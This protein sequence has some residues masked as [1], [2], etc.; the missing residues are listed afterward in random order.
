MSS[1]RLA[2]LGAALGLVLTTSPAQAVDLSIEVKLADG[3]QA[4]ADRLGI[5]TAMIEAPMRKVVVDYFQANRIGEFL[6]EMGEGQSFTNR[7]LGVD[8]A[9]D[10]DAVMLGAAGNFAFNRD[11]SLEPT[12]GDQFIKFGR[13]LN[14]TVMAGLN[15]EMFGLAPITLYTNY[16]FL[17]H[18]YGPFE[19]R[20]N[21]FGL[22][23][24][25]QL[26]RPAAKS[27]LE[28]LF[29]W[30]GFDITTG[31]EQEKGVLWLEQQRLSGAVPYP[32]Q[33]GQPATS[34]RIDASGE[35]SF[36]TRAINIPIEVSTNLRLFHI[37]SLYAGLGYDIKVASA[38]N[39]YMDA[40][41]DL[42]AQVD[43]A[44]GRQQFRAAS[45]RIQVTDLE[46]LPNGS[47]RALAGV[48]ANLFLVKIFVHG[49]LLFFRDPIAT[50]GGGVRFAY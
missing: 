26:F 2:S 36:Y 44:G 42:T 24:Q 5:T 3:A 13:G 17:K 45:A 7:G 28:Q 9:S 22:H 10:F 21:N 49:N 27:V 1:F 8:Y 34:V 43:G 29:R 25:L 23:M 46:R 32:V 19:G 11:S 14:V 16:F 12:G 15:L 40:S 48:Q 4:F 20:S 47:L 37:L 35:I 39:G 30:G 41:M 6:R 38:V 50:L 18:R 33:P 31:V